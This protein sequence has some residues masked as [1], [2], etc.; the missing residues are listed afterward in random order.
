MN[1]RK[2][3]YSCVTSIRNYCSSRVL[4]IRF[5]PFLT[6]YKQGHRYIE[7][8]ILALITNQAQKSCRDVCYKGIQ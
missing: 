6:F 1:I 2:I 7:N 8:S 5:C 4:P 3:V